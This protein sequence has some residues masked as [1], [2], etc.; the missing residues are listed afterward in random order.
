MSSLEQAD[1]EE[2]MSCWLADSGVENAYSIAPALVGIGLH[3]EE[4]A[5]AKDAFP[6]DH[7]SNALNWLEALVSSSTLVCTIEESISRISDLVMAVKKFAYDD[8]CTLRDVDVHDSIQ[9]TLTILGHKLRQRQIFIAEANIERDLKVL[10]IANML[11]AAFGGYVSCTS[12]SR[13]ILVRTA[14]GRI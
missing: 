8:R 4:L 3:K 1:A 2:E 10:G 6:P 11:T 7:F 13:S 5:C 12:L 14:G 9:S